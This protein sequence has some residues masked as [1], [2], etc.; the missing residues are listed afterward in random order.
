MLGAQ[1]RSLRFISLGRG[2]SE[3]GLKLAEGFKDGIVVFVGDRRNSFFKLRRAPG[4]FFEIPGPIHSLHHASASINV[5]YL[6]NQ[7]DRG[8]NIVETS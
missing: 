8:W 7:D 3:V 5:E 1:E 2:D 6:V 4:L